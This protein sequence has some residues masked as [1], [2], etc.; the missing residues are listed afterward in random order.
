M[1]LLAGLYVPDVEVAGPLQGYMSSR[2]ETYERTTSLR[3]APNTLPA[4]AYDQAVDAVAFAAADRSAPEYLRTTAQCWEGVIRDGLANGTRQV[5]GAGQ[6]APPP[7]DRTVVGNEPATVVVERPVRVVYDCGTRFVFY[8]DAMDD[9][10]VRYDG[11]GA[12][13]LRV[14]H[15][16]PFVWVAARFGPVRF[17]LGDQELVY[18]SAVYRPCGA[19][20][21]YSP[22]IY[23]W[24]GWHVGLGVFISTRVV[25]PRVYVGPRVIVTRPSRPVVV[26]NRGHDNGRRDDGWHDPR[27]GRN[28]GPHD[29]GR[30]AVPRSGND[31]GT[32]DRDARGYGYRAEPGRPGSTVSGNGGPSRV[33]GGG[34]P[35]RVSGGGG[36]SRVSGG[37]RVAVPKGGGV[38]RGGGY[39]PHTDRPAGGSKPSRGGHNR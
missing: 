11:Y 36:P 38:S 5:S 23:P 26:V 39:Q 4:E 21:I 12:G 16:G 18:T 24:Y 7:D 22:A 17:W 20:V 15:G 9:L 3:E 25:A 10:A 34:G 19:R 33:S 13:V 6:Q 2:C 32:R 37:E 35:S 1:W 30:V 14:R 8:N 31:G 28:D 29:G 27:G